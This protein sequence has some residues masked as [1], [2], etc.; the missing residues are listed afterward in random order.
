MNEMQSRMV[1][2][3]VEEDIIP[4]E[5]PVLGK[6]WAPDGKS[7]ILFLSEERKVRLHP[8]EFI[9]VYPSKSVVKE[10]AFL[11]NRPRILGSGRGPT[12]TVLSSGD[13]AH[14]RKLD[15]TNASGTALRIQ[16]NGG[17]LLK[18]LPMERAE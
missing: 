17:G 5:G 8:M 16:Y 3:I 11:R 18:V 12:E 15:V 4:D 9:S 14:F 13:T 1:Y 6:E 10:G 2:E 7:V